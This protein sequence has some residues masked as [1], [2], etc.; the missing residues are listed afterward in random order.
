MVSSVHYTFI[1]YALKT[2]IWTLIGSYLGLSSPSMSP[3]KSDVGTDGD[4]GDEAEE[5]KPVSVTH[6]SAGQRLE[7]WVVPRLH[8][9]QVF[10]GLFRFPYMGWGW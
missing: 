2:K 7:P 9:M 6:N 10:I 1:A 4:S 8:D 3:S 5:K